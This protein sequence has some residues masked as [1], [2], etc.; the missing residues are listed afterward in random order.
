MC[1]VGIDGSLVDVET[2]SRH[3]HIE[4]LGGNAIRIS[5]H[6]EYC[7]HPESAQ[8]QG[9][10]DEEGAKSISVGTWCPLTMMMEVS[11]A[12]IWTAPP[13]SNYS[14]TSKPAA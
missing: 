12:E 1:S 14:Q 4:F 2:K 5:G 13:C 10:I 11:P 8:L 3:Y 9:S 7:P 6:P